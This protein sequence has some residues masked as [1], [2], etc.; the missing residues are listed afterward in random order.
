[1]SASRLRLFSIAALGIN[2]IV[3]SGIFALPTELA[4]A[5]GTSSPL[6]FVAAALILGVVAI[7]FAACARI[8]TRDGGPYAYAREAF[9][10][11]A[12]YVIGAGV[13]AAIVTTWATTCAAIPAQLDAIVP[14]FA[15]HPRLVATAFVIAMGLANLFGV[16]AGAWVSDVLVVVKLAPLIVFA[17]VGM[18]F[19]DWSNFGPVSTHGLGAAL[20]PAF[21]ALSGFETAT[22]PAGTA[23]RP[24]RDVPLAVITSLG[25][26]VLLYVMIQIVVVGV[27]PT[28]AASERPLVEASRAFLG[29]GGASV[30][31]ALAT[32]AMI[33]LAAA[34]ALAGARM[35]AIVVADRVAV[36]I[37]TALTA[38]GTL[39][40]D[41]GPLVEYTTYLL[42]AQYGATILAAPILTL[43]RRRC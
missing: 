23:E 2:T 25:G 8:V 7:A 42:F 39:L 35:L 36:A 27:S 16:R 6:A 26:A 38:I 40:V 29:D 32:I 14:G 43:R 24:T 22:I 13:Y 3:G 30:M 19:V 18:F 1:M 9:G 17:C 33:G 28:A 12:G 41:F 11:I 4:R 10:S 5:M 21:Y 31:A 34:M 15:A 37:T 20:L